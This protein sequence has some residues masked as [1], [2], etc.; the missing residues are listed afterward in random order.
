MNIGQFFEHRLKSHFP[1]AL[2]YETGG[3]QISDRLFQKRQGE[4]EFEE[5][6]FEDI[7]L[8]LTEVRTWRIVMD[9]STLKILSI[10]GLLVGFRYDFLRFRGTGK[11]DEWEIF[12]GKF[13]FKTLRMI[14]LSNE[15]Y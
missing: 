10:D 7:L 9:S 3:Y 14:E 2:K 15:G 11:D 12:Y 6:P 8:V 1:E 5:V 13:D 4:K